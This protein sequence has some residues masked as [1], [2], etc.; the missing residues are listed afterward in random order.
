MAAGLAEECTVQIAYAIGVAEPVGLYVDTHGTGQAEDAEL[1]ALTR[2]HFPL[3]PK[4]IIQH[5]RLRRPIYR[6][7]AAYGHFGRTEKEGFDWEKTDVARLLREEALG[8][9]RQNGSSGRKLFSA[10]PA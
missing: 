7:T 6:Q 5:F 3:T 4:N 1:V 2:K 9:S 8:K 10:A